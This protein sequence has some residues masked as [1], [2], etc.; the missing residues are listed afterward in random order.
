MVSKAKQA[1]GPDF[2]SRLRV[3]PGGLITGVIGR[4]GICFFC[5]FFKKI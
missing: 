3:S 1:E 5:F 4:K 2:S